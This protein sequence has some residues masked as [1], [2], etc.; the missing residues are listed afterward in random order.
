VDKV[1]AAGQQS[2]RG[3]QERIDFASSFQTVYHFQNI[4]VSG[5]SYF[6]ILGSIAKL[7]PEEPWIAH[8][9]RDFANDGGEIYLPVLA[10]ETMP[11]G[12]V[13]LSSF[14]K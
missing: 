8:Q 2:V 9:R 7:H 10:S 1:S 12:D 14:E 13:I 4:Y 6:P 5:T 11:E 3:R